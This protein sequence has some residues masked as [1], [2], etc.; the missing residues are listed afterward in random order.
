MSLLLLQREN[1]DFDAAVKANRLGLDERAGAAAQSLLF[2]DISKTVPIAA[3]ETHIAYIDMHGKVH[4]D[5][6]NAYTQCD[7]EQW[8]GVVSLCASEQNTYGLKYDG[9]VVAAGS[10]AFSQCE[11]SS[12]TDIISLCAC[13][14]AVFGLKD[15]GTVHFCRPVRGLV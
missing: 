13:S 10:N 6:N 3:S 8:Q 14:N 15:D 7:V 4:A 9:T 11:V 2:M 5:G 1:G 12:W